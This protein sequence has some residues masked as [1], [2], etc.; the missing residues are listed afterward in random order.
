V[1]L[2]DHDF[3]EKL[4]VFAETDNGRVVDEEVAGEVDATELGEGQ[5]ESL[6]AEIGNWAGGIIAVFGKTEVE[7]FEERE[8]VSD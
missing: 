5:R 3:L 4:T 8:T 7:V 6:Y 1:A 2:E